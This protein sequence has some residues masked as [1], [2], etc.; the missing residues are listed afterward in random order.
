MT[1][2]SFSTSRCD[3]TSMT[4]TEPARPSTARSFSA[5]SDSSLSKTRY[6]S[7]SVVYAGHG[8][9]IKSKNIDAYRGLDVKDKI[10][11]STQP[12]DSPKEP[13]KQT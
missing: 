7:G 2:R 12:V 9:F 11:S 13:H 8:W 10:V 6:R 1:A 3:A 4:M 5:G